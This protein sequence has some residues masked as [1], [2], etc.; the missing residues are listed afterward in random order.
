MIVHGTT[1]TLSQVVGVGSVATVSI[2]QLTFT[3]GRT[4]RSGTAGNGAGLANL[5]TLTLTDCTISGNT[6]AVADGGALYNRGTVT[7][8]NCTISGNTASNGG[9]LYNRGTATLTNC[10]IS[11]NTASSN[12]VGGLQNVSTVTL[13]NCTIS[14]NGAYGLVNIAG[15]TANLINTIVAGNGVG[16]PFVP[17]VIGPVTSLGHN[18]IGLTDDSTG[19]V[20]SDLTG[21]LSSP[22][23]PQLGPL[24]DNGGP[25]QT[26]AL[27]TGSPA[28]D[29]GASGA[30][31]PTTDQ[32][33]YSRIDGSV[34]IGA[35]ELGGVLLA[36]ATISVPGY[37]VTYDGS[38]HTATG[39]ATGTQG[40][41]LSADLTFTGTTHTNA[42]SYN[43][44]WTFHDPTGNYQDA[45]GTVT[46]LVTAQ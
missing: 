41:D 39:T 14:G 36:S 34:D 32:R 12:L 3:G 9:A 40:I 22:L 24:A 8:T 6:A 35:F 7:L 28:I 17:D 33:G 25:T 29:T 18:L 45:S 1:G 4:N 2:S 27:L 31:I 43:D 10:T 19:W 15:E 37:S 21:T 16:T 38:P 20:A 11:G 44:T 46:D 30:G 42:G 23:D 26:M 13:T 5:G